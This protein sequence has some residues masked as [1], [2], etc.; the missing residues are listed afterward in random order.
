MI[1]VL[2]SVIGAANRAQAQVSQNIVG[3]TYYA[4]LYGVF[5]NDSTDNC[6]ALTTPVTGMLAVVSA[7][8]GGYIDLPY[9]NLTKLT[10]CNLS[11]PGN[12]V[13]R[14]YPTGPG[15]NNPPPAPPACGLHITYS[16]DTYPAVQCLQEGQCGLENMYVKVDTA[17]KPMMLYTCSAPWLD[18]VRFKGLTSASGTTCARGGACPTN[19]GVLF[20]NA[21]NHTADCNTIN[22]GYAGYG[23]PPHVNSLYF[24]NTSTWLEFNENAN[25]IIVT[26]VRGDFTDA[27]PSGYAIEG[28]GAPGDPTYNNQ[29]FGIG[30]E[31]APYHP[32]NTD[33]N[34]A[35]VFGLTGYA[36]GWYAIYESSD[37]HDSGCVHSATISAN[38]R[39]NHLVETVGSF[40]EGA[41]DDGSNHWNYLE[42]L[43]NQTYSVR[44]LLPLFLG[45]GDTYNNRI[46][47]ATWAY[48]AVENDNTIMVSPG[49]Y[50][51]QTL[52]VSNSDDGTCAS[53]GG[54]IKVWCFYDGTGWKPMGNGS[55]PTFKTPALGDATASSLLA[56]G[57]V[58]GRVPVT[59][60]TG[61][62][63]TL[64]GTYNSGYT[65]NQEATAST[66]VTYNLPSGTAAGGQQYCIA[67]SYNGSAGDY[68]VLTLNANGIGKY[69]IYNGARSVSNGNIQSSGALGDSICVV[70]IDGSNWQVVGQPVGTWTLH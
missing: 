15:W 46:L 67:N 32:S 14:C 25:G 8:G 21:G 40:P 5:G 45:N 50:T 68:G 1:L 59:I 36:D 31:Q 4:A 24:Q 43:P 41:F 7:A 17:D 61:T 2:V 34:Y 30:V 12:I 38:S 65:F 39:Y 47:N 28:K 58:D 56:T 66:G 42:D 23:G 19:K 70:R 22:D 53:H 62:S 60:T 54:L 37:T 10:S 48:Y 35:G 33:C 11:I 3:P 52:W 57:I 20:G 63:Y 9:G 27:N 6:A 49:P 69:I 26:S 64:G 18:N 44:Q 13:L 55:S 29:F 16:G 51:Y